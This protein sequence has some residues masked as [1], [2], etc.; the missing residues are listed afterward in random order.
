[1]DFM[2]WMQVFGGLAIFIS[3]MK[4]MSDGLHHVTGEKI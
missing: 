1:M 2:Q 4:L 3:G